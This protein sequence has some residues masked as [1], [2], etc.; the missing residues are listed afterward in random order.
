MPEPQ[1]FQ[2]ITPANRADYRRLV[3]PLA[4]ACW[5]EFMLHDAFSDRYWNDLFERFGEYQFGLLDPASGQAIAMGNSLPLHWDGDLQDLPDE[6]WDWA[7]Q[8]AVHDHQA[9]LEARTQCA[10]QI[11]IHPDYRSRG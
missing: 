1:D 5:P 8:Q 4:E 7:M 9:G 3:N 11:A 6:G 2:L 10:I